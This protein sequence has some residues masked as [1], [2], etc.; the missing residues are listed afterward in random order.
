MAREDVEVNVH[1]I[2]TTIK[3]V[4]AVQMEALSSS[5]KAASLFENNARIEGCS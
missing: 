5:R 2:Q 1:A 4:L 3:R